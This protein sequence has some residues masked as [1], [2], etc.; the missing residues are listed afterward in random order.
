MR[1]NRLWIAAVLGLA[2]AACSYYRSG[3]A[4]APVHES[5]QSPFPL[6]PVATY[7]IVARDGATGQMGVAVQSH[8]FSVGSVV[9]WAEAGVGAIATQSLVN[10]S[11]GPKGLDLM[12]S[13]VSA[14]DA[15]SQLIAA[16]PGAHY[17]QVA[18]IDAKGDMATHTGELCIAE[19]SHLNR[20]YPDGT[21]VSVQANLMGPTGVPEAML[22]AFDATPGPLQWR[23]MG[24]LFAAQARGGDIRGKQSAAMRVVEG[25]KQPEPWQGRLI[26]IRVDDFPDPL[27]E[28]ARLL[29]LAEAYNAMNAGDLAM[30][31]NDA[32]GA[33]EH[34]SR[35]LRLRPMHEMAFWTAVSLV[36]AQRVDESLPYFAYAFSD[37][38]DW[39]ETLRRLPRSRLFPDD[40]ALME[41]ILATPASPTLP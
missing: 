13:G 32:A 23:L 26:D 6:R 18:F 7:S 12:R 30:E 40:P 24:A 3:P 29:R 10:V 5:L 31:H 38:N 15:L 33:L 19:A 1:H 20:I 39:R 25:E 14:P 34:Y 17:R 21:V 28:L 36:N 35:A 22:A 16:D 9:P 27:P 37:T 11:F 2:A 4:D 41:R 8:W